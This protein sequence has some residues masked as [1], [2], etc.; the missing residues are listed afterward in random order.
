MAGVPWHVRHR[1]CGPPSA[2]IWGE[3][4]CFSIFVDVFS[5]SEPQCRDTL[6]PR[7]GPRSRLA[8]NPNPTDVSLGISVHRTKLEQEVSEP[9]RV[10]GLDRA[11]THQG[12]VE[13]EQKQGSRPSGSG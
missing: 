6:P 11:R 3:R 8:Y 12:C 1:V 7:N 9:D 4:S 13:N 5:C 2:W 10:S